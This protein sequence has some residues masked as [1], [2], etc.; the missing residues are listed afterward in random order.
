MHLQELFRDYLSTL[1][2]QELWLQ[3]FPAEF[4]DYDQ[5]KEPI[6]K[7]EIFLEYLLTRCCEQKNCDILKGFQSRACARTHAR[8]NTHTESQQC[9]GGECK[10]CMSVPERNCPQGSQKEGIALK[11]DA[12]LRMTPWGKEYIHPESGGALRVSHSD[13]GF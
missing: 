7:Q 8:T 5:L 11:W 10:R 2:T 13:G 1:E 12:L 6:I 3:S 9:N 4:C